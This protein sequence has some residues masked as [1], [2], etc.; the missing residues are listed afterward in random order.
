MSLSP[1][2]HSDVIRIFCKNSLYEGSAL[3][4]IRLGKFSTGFLGP[5]NVN[6]FIYI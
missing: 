5:K 3:L 1:T 4:H 6:R 2:M